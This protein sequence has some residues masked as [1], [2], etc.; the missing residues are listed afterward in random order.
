[1]NAKAMTDGERRAI[2]WNE[3]ERLAFKPRS[4]RDKRTWL[5][6]YRTKVVVFWETEP[7]SYTRNLQLKSVELR[8]PF[9]LKCLCIIAS[10]DKYEVCIQASKST[11]STTSTTFWQSHV[12]SK[13]SSKGTLLNPAAKYPSQDRQRLPE[14]VEAV[15]NGMIFHPRCHTHLEKIAGAIDSQGSLQSELSPH[16]IRIGGGIENPF[17]FLFHL[18][19]QFCL[20]SKDVREN[21]KRRLKDLFVTAIQ[22][23]KKTVTPKKLFDYG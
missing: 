21:E 15:L 8:L 14:D 19:Y 4:D 23:K 3:I 7:Y 13:Y 1:M 9:S 11:T 12:D 10:M 18:R 6:L 2:V 20:I 5:N 17:V 22:E 16:E